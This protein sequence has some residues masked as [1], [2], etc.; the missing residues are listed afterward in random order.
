MTEGEISNLDMAL[1]IL[2]NEQVTD[3]TRRECFYCIKS[4]METLLK[5][6]KYLYNTWAMLKLAR[7][8]EC[9]VVDQQE[10]V[11]F[12]ERKKSQCVY[13]KDKRNLLGMQ[14]WNCKG[15]CRVD[16]SFSAAE[17]MVG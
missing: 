4:V 13:C 8:L 9:D 2:L 1:N 17:R 15:D 14:E 16:S 12:L 5:G 7:E 10:K 11:H 3:G 6:V